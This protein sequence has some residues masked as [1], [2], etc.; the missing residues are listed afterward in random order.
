MLHK[1]R[2]ESIFYQKKELLQI[3]QT[4]LCSKL[5]FVLL[6]ISFITIILL[7]LFIIKFALFFYR[8]GILKINM[9]IN[10]ITSNIKIYLS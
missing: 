6:I 9:F 1:K 7:L 5:T 2:I 8:D 10:L 3:C 4:I